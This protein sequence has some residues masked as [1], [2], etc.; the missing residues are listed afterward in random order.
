[1]DPKLEKKMMNAYLAA[2]LLK[3]K[4]HYTNDFSDAIAMQNKRLQKLMKIAYEI[5]FYRERFDRV[6]MKPEDF[7]TGDDLAKFPIL[8]KDELREWMAKEVENPKYKDW[9]IDTTSGSTGKPLSIIFSPKEKAYMKAHGTYAPDLKTLIASGLIADSLTFIPYSEG[10]RFALEASVETEKSGKVVNTM[11]C[12]AQYQQ[13]LKGL[14]E[15]DIANL[16]EEANKR[17]E[18]PGMKIDL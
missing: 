1:M 2:D 17:G 3:M 12:G 8:T 14:N 10:E 13:Y 5:P 18:Y 7:R 4:R 11:E 16:I 9:I 15:N 6:G